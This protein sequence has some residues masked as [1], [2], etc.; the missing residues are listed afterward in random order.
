M[1][2]LRRV[3]QK[4][5]LLAYVITLGM[6]AAALWTAA[7][8]SAQDYPASQIRNYMGEPNG[9][10]LGIKG[11]ADDADAV[12]WGCNGSLNQ[13]WHWGPENGSNPGYYELINGDGECLGV[14]SN[15]KTV[16]AD[17]VGWNCNGEANQW[18]FENG[19]NQI[20][21]NAVIYANLQNLNS[22]W[23]VGVEGGVNSQGQQLIQ[24]SWQ[25][26]P[27]GANQLWN[28]PNF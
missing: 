26:V 5:R 8:A 23:D 7:P 21:V 17:I 13:D 25:P 16:G 9:M 2:P 12:L 18:W 4:P 14:L 28:A 15:S 3:R 1:L 27:Q 20:I 19:A 11:G 6:A 24:F 10:C 22:G